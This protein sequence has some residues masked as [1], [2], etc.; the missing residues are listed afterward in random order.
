M[1]GAVS[2]IWISYNISVSEVTYFL[3]KK[4]KDDRH[5]GFPFLVDLNEHHLA[6]GRPS[7]QIKYI[8]KLRNHANTSH[9]NSTNGDTNKARNTATAKFWLSN[10]RWSSIEEATTTFIF[11]IKKVVLI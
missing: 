4:S 8:T 2:N 11:A 9:D 3:G 5:R 10:A 6:V 7:L 1:I